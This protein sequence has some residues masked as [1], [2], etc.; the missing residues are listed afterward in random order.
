MKKKATSSQANFTGDK[1]YHSNL[2]GNG[3]KLVTGTHTHFQRCYKGA[4]NNKYRCFSRSLL[5]SEMK[6]F[7]FV[8]ADKGMDAQPKY[9]LEKKFHKA[10]VIQGYYCPYS[11]KIQLLYHY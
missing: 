4:A 5:Q 6:I 1:D 10:V 9:S 3:R 7:F 8:Q 11:V 2:A